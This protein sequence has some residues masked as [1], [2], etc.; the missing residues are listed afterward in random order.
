ME[1]M[2]KIRKFC[3]ILVF[4]IIGTEVYSQIG[5]TYY[6]SNILAVNT[7]KNNKISGEL[8]VFANSDIENTAMEMDAYYNFKSYEYH[9][10]S[11]GTGFRLEVFSGEDAAITVPFKLEVFPFQKFKRVL[12]LFELAP[13]IYFD[14]SVK[15]RSL[16][17]L[18]YSFEKK[19]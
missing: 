12:F 13:E 2:R 16:L 3:I 6:T 19:N 5:I 10:F 17:G 14:D 7:S 9:R 18:R 4:I 1:K 11:I 8:K 15:L